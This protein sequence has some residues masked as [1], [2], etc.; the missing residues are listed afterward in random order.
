MARH[1]PKQVYAILLRSVASTL[2]TLGRDPNRL[3]A[4]LGVTTVLHTWT[5]D[6]RF[7]PHVHCIVT[8]GGLSLD[9]QRWVHA[10][11]N[12]LFPVKVMGKL[13]RGK[14]LD[15]LSSAHTRGEL[16]LPPQ[17]SAPSVFERL[18]DRLYGKDWVVYAKRP[19]AGPRQLFEYLGQ[20]THRVAISNHRILEVNDTSVVIKTRGK[21]T[22]KM[23]PPEF[24]RR[25]LQHVLPPGFTKIRHY[26]LMAP[27]SVNGELNTARELL[28][29]RPVEQEGE[30]KAKFETPLELMKHLTGID[31][32][33]C[34][35]CN[36]HS[37]VRIPLLD[38][39][40]PR[41]PP[42]LRAAP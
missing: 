5:R 8:G 18:R 11:P 4:K 38:A 1:N 34:P 37:I 23:S 13:F 31:L 9:G 16:A 29:G 39:S 30:D 41:A 32:S 12:H 40:P 14:F 24:I 28:A 17:F 42:L 22:A 3:H 25:F 2:L 35:V 36:R 6:L 33:V 15:A 19:F 21:A 7:H 20:Y 27:S 10:R 26:G